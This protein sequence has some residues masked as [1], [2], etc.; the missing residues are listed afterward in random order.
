MRRRPGS[1]AVVSVPECCLRE[2]DLL[3]VL[4]CGGLGQ[5][6]TSADGELERP[7]LGGSV[8]PPR[9]D[10]VRR[11]PLDT[12]RPPLGESVRLPLMAAAGERMRRAATRNFGGHLTLGLPPP[13]TRLVA[14]TRLAT[15]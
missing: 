12:D 6:S 5:A 3:F 1:L 14:Q 4:R 10:S 2:P 7:P 11:S 13:Q 15:A 8:L 9:G